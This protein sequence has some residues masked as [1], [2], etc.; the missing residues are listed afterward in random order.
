[1]TRYRRAVTLAEKR[2]RMAAGA[3]VGVTLLVLAWAISLVAGALAYAVLLLIP[4][5]AAIVEFKMG[6]RD[7]ID[8]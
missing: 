5:V 2:R 7:S 4:V 6:T 1:M 3:V 8:R